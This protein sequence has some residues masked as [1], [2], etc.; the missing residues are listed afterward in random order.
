ME[1]KKRLRVQGS[2]EVNAVLLSDEGEEYPVFLESLH[3][4]II[5]PTLLESGYSIVSMPYGFSKN[6]VTLDDLPVEDMTV[7]GQALEYM[8]NTI[9]TKLSYDEISSHIDA[10]EA[11]GLPT[12]E[13]N[14]TINTREEFIEYLE[15]VDKASDPN[16]FYPINYFV[17]PNARFSIDEYIDTRNAKY[18][19]IM[20]NRR[21]MSI[22]K[23]HKLFD[24]LCSM[25]LISA[26]AKP[27]DVLEA[28]FS[29]GFD[30]VNLA[31]MA[32]RREQ[33]REELSPFISGGSAYHKNTIGFTDN[34]GDIIVAPSQ[35]A[36][37]WKPSVRGEEFDRLIA[38]IPMGEVAVMQYH[39]AALQE[40]V[41]CNCSN[42]MTVTY[43]TSL[44][45]FSRWSQPTI[46]VESITGKNLTLSLELALPSKKDELI[47]D[48][49]LYALA[50][51]LYNKRKCP[52]KVSSYDA[53]LASGFTPKSAVEYV[54]RNLGTYA[55]DQQVADMT[56]ENSD[57]L[58]EIGYAT[59]VDYFNGNPISERAKSFLDDIVD[60]LICTDNVAIGKKSDEQYS[61][62]DTYHFF[63]AVH[64]VFDISIEEIWE[65][66]K[67]LTPN[68][69]FITFEHNGLVAKMPIALLEG[70]IKGYH[71]DLNTYLVERGQQAT[72]FTYITKVAREVGTEAAT[73]HVAVEFYMVNC[74][75]PDVKR[76]LSQLTSIYKERVETTIAN[77]VYRE[78]F[79]ESSNNWCF[80]VFFEIAFKG[81]YTFPKQLGGGTT[82]VDGNMKQSCVNAVESKIDSLNTLCNYM[83][84][85][86]GRIRMDGYCTNAYITPTRVIPRQGVTLKEYPFYTLW[87]NWRSQ[88]PSV[89]EQLVNA[90]VLPADFVA[91]ENRYDSEQ[92]YHRE[93]SELTTGD[94][95]LAYYNRAVAEVA[96]ADPSVEFVA[97]TH[98]IEYLYPGL[99][100][101]DKEEKLLDTPR[102][103]QPIIRLGLVR[104]LTY[105]NSNYLRYPSEPAVVKDQYMHEFCGFSTEALL[106]VPDVINK[107]PSGA[108]KLIV[109]GDYITPMDTF[110]PYNFRRIAELI[111]LGYPI[112]HIYD[113]I[114]VFAA[115]DG[116]LWE[117]QV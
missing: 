20:S 67:A 108:S 15:A 73:R 52:Y 42:N 116:K 57:S 10:K 53:L 87:Y 43:S 81:T 2:N 85:M 105:D 13:T 36:V 62:D 84:N 86:S 74:L 39:T 95:L 44:L 5:F 98:P 111:S 19:L 55:K 103:G 31:I 23:F 117:V 30:G 89:W 97:V 100:S 92:Y 102:Q 61:R 51:D 47:E 59:L 17:S 3:N 38:S 4:T 14:Y 54:V 78:K 82:S 26:A 109:A 21:T 91:W 1:I 113:R 24:W 45:K 16:D 96:D 90:G 72:F 94:S 40:V 69:N 32:K 12:P 76:I 115:S 18:V 37:D 46:R 34:A 65:K 58:P 70:A 106:N 48:C 35:R 33:R 80:K 68:D 79:L 6:G 28:Y 64:N 112:V 63:Y 56:D 71:N 75:R 101:E 83:C 29:W 66:I 110:E 7:T 8:Y 114:Y 88:S 60:G 49:L 41:V 22:Q 50:R 11:A 107:L 93:L 99:Y 27:L 25:G 104:E 77:P 9:G